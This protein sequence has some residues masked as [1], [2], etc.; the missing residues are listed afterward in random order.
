MSEQIVLPVEAVDGAPQTELEALIIDNNLKIESPDETAAN[1][2]LIVQS[3][4]ETVETNEAPVE[5]PTIIK[6]KEDA[7]LVDII[8][9]MEEDRKKFIAHVHNKIATQES[10]FEVKHVVKNIH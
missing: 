4:P 2:Q 3:E 5:G 10:D 7:N 1:V 8:N 6:F 9:S